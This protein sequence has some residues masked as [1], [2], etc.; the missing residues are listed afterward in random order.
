VKEFWKDLYA[1]DCFTASL[2]RECVK[3]LQRGS[4]G[5]IQSPPTAGSNA[6]QASRSPTL[7]EQLLLAPRRFLLVCAVSLC[8]LWSEE[9]QHGAAERQ[10][11]RRPW[12]A[13]ACC[14]FS[15]AS[16]L[17]PHLSKCRASAHGQQAGPAVREKRQQAAALQRRKRTIPSTSSETSEAPAGTRG[18]PRGAG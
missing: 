13:A 3:P 10:P 18:C 6:N 15:P 5:K 2:A 7:S 12:S 16:L 9:P 11:K 17:A 4:S 1:I 14:R 8:A